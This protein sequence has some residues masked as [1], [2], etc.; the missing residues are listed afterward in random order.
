MRRS[1]AW[2]FVLALL[3]NSFALAGAETI[4]DAHLGG[5]S[6]YSQGG[7]GNTSPEVTG[8]SHACH[9]SFHF[10]GLVGMPL[11]FAVEADK[12]RSIEFPKAVFP[13]PTAESFRPPRTLS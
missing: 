12:P 4:P 8:C 11:A 9:M 2:L 7:D 5:S 6:S 10:M 3:G 1:V 13:P